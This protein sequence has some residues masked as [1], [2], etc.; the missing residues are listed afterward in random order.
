MKDKIYLEAKKQWGQNK[1]MI[2]A[3]EEFAEAAAALL[4][5]VNEKV[6]SLHEVY[7]ELADVEIMSEQMREY[8]NPSIID[9]EKDR[10][11]EKVAKRLGLK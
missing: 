7:E 11:L 1:Q 8:F 6:E 5:V 2:A 9:S 4:R 3:A 10:K